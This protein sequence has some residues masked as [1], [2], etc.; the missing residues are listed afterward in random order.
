MKPYHEEIDLVRMP[1]A[2]KTFLLLEDIM[3]EGRSETKR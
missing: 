1:Q 3:T 2:K